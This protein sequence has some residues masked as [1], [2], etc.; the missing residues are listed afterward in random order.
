MTTTSIAAACGPESD[1]AGVRW[2]LAQD[3]PVP[4]QRGPRVVAVASRHG[5]RV[6]QAFEEAG[7]FY[8]YEISPAASNFIG[9]QP[10]PL[11]QP[12]AT[13]VETVRLLRDCDLVLCAGI[14]VQCRRLLDGLG[15]RY[16][17]DYAGERLEQAVAR[18]GRDG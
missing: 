10:C 15:V 2:G 14:G 11:S 18:A 13:P 12:G 4:R 1:Y 6:D 5:E 16:R 8:L 9:R 17:L 3:A 7:D